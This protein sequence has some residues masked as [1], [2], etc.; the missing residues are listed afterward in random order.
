MPWISTIQVLSNDP[1]NSEA[2]VSLSGNGVYEGPS[3]EFSS[4]IIMAPSGKK[5]R[6]A[7]LWKSKTR[8]T[9]YWKSLAQI[10]DNEMF[11]LDNVEFPI[12][13]PVLGTGELAFWFFPQDVTFYED[14]VILT[15]NDPLNSTTSISLEGSGKPAPE[16]MGADLWYHYIT[17]GYDNSVKAF[18]YLPDLNN[19]GKHE[20][21]AASED[22]YI[23]CFNGNADDPADVL[24]KRR[25]IPGIFTAKTAW[26]VPVT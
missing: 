17:E 24:G 19:D 11:Y 25:Y 10:L 2:D 12:Q 3:A 13:I 7:G 20:V 22:N 6:N 16:T 1:M 21:V 26:Y 15:T 18:T 4:R 23:R 14:N 9:R 5:L 8:E